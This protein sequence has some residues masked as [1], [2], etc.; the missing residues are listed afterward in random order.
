MICLKYHVCIKP[1]E[2]GGYL[3]TIPALPHIFAPGDSPEEALLNVEEITRLVLEV[4]VFNGEEIPADIESED[5]ITLEFKIDP[6]AL[7][8]KTPETLGE[9]AQ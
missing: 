2:D 7:E 8:G 1:D 5:G 9:G 6:A 4:M 3:A